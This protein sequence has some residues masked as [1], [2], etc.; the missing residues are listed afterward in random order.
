MTKVIV[1]AGSCGFKV[2]IRS[3]FA[4]NGLQAIQC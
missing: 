4:A 3:F 2:I 1:E